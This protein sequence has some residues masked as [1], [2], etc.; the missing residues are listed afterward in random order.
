MKKITELEAFLKSHIDSPVPT[1][2]E[3]A[4][5]IETGK[6]D[7]IDMKCKDCKFR[8]NVDEVIKV[9]LREFK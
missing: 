2:C 9:L 1:P 8:K 7:C 4:Y 3:M 5:Q 6:R